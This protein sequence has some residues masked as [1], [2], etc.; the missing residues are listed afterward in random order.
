[1]RLQFPVTLDE[2]GR[3]TSCQLGWRRQLSGDV[4]TKDQQAFRVRQRQFNPACR[5]VSAVQKT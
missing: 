1:M 4:P 3:Y 5:S 2:S